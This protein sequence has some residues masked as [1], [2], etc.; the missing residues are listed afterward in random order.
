MYDTNIIT[1]IHVLTLITGELLVSAPLLWTVDTYNSKA[2]STNTV[3]SVVY[4]ESTILH[5]FYGSISPTE[6]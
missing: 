6:L 3:N 4:I 1:V 5:P 2:S